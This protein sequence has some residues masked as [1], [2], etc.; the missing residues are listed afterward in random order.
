MCVMRV[1]AFLFAHVLTIGTPRCATVLLIQCL[2]RR[3]PTMLVPTCTSGAT[4]RGFF[5]LAMIVI[6]PGS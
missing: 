1:C 4:A 6:G 2:G 3:T 5:S